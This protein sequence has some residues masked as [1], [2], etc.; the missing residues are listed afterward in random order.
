MHPGVR[1]GKSARDVVDGLHFMIC[2]GFSPYS[3]G[4]A[5]GEGDGPVSGTFSFHF[6]ATATNALSLVSLPTNTI[7]VRIHHRGVTLQEI[8][9][10][11]AGHL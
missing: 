4:V 11:N 1:E 9:A 3:Q 8:V 5:G 10:L 7:I 6:I 2:P